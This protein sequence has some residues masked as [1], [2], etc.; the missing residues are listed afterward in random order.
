M[1]GP[2]PSEAP[3]NRR[4]GPS[5]LISRGSAGPV[6][7][8][9]LRRWLLPPAFASMMLLAT[10]NHVCQDV[11]V[12]PFLWVVPLSL[13]LV[14]FIICFDNEG[15][16]HR[17][18]YGLAT[19]AVIFTISAA[20]VFAEQQR[21]VLDTLLYSTAL[22]LI[23]MLCHGEL[24]R[25]KPPARYLTAFY[26]MCSAGGAVGGVFVAVVCPLIFNAY[27]ET[28][29]GLILAYVMAAVVVFP[30]L[31]RRFQAGDSPQPGRFVPGFAA[32]SAE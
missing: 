23:C 5:L 16:Y 32:A 28:P 7:L 9:R 26:L 10:T 30:G 12:V 31:A 17:F 18:W 2:R 22:F 3:A 14:S 24:V 8:A 1:D 4:P 6:L 15:W 25:R 29:S 21:M 13:Y 19:L 27:W 11:A 20:S